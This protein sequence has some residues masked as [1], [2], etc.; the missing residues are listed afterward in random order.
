MGF[1]HLLLIS[2]FLILKKEE[3]SINR[4]EAFENLIGKT[5]IAEG[6]WGDQ[7]KFK[8]EITCE[9]DLNKSIIICKSTGYTNTEQTEYGARNHG[10]RWYDPE[11]GKIRF[12]EFDLFGSLTEGTVDFEEKNIIYQY[13]YHGSNITD[14]WEY[15]NDSLYNFK[16]GVYNHGTWEQV[17]LSTQFKEK[18]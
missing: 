7:S 2:L 16:V 13:Q 8:Q 5:W 9:Y 6:N 14:M 4:F 12:W 1:K 15:V 11:L 18:H 17:Y 10:I 3:Q